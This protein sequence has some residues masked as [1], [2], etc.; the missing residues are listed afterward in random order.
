MWRARLLHYW[1]VLREPAWQYLVV[2]PLAVLSAMAWVR[3]E[4]LPPEIA[5]KLKMP[6]WLPHW[7]WYYW[8]LATA[9]VLLVLILEGSFR[10]NRKLGTAKSEERPHDE[11]L[12]AHTEELRLQR[13]AHEREND[14]IRK[15]LNSAF[16]PKTAE[17]ARIEE[18]EAKIR[19]LESA[20]AEL[21]LVFDP[22]DPRCV[23]DKRYW[24]ESEFLES[25]RWSIG[26]KNNSETKSADGLTVRAKEFW[27]VSCSIATSHRGPYE[28]AKREPVF[29]TKDTLEPGALEFVEMFGM[30][31]NTSAMGS[32]VFQKSHE[33]VIEAR[34]RD[35]K[36][37][38][39]VL[40]YDPT[41][42]PTITKMR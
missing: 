32:G 19:S 39:I 28:E 12:A 27:F 9:L 31:G 8:A 25:R 10:E 35:A 6:Q 18:L 3:D 40:Q 36:T 29:F 4:F 20:R 26:V 30:D 37:V 13:L 7:P 33:F 14:P 24:F 11:I 41:T 34:A 1:R 23:K 21:E 22:N 15:V 38:Q 5:A 16:D 2:V 17:R 42:P